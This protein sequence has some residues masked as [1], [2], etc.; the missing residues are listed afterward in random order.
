MYKAIK[1]TKKI[2]IKDVDKFN[3]KKTK[4]SS[5]LRNFEISVTYDT[6]KI[7]PTLHILLKKS[8]F[9]LEINVIFISIIKVGTHFN[10]TGNKWQ[11]KNVP[12]LQVSSNITVEAHHTQLYST[13]YIKQSTHI[14]LFSRREFAEI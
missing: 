11:Q 14:Y 5:C 2:A 10:I 9:L 8:N 7:Y 4:S 12:N 1:Y 13:C 6:H 3:P